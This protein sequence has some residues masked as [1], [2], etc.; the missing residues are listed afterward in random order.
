MRHI[1]SLGTLL[2]MSVVLLGSPAAA[3]GQAGGVA[4]E[5]LSPFA[6]RALTLLAVLTG[7]GIL[8]FLLLRFG[9]S[10]NSSDTQD[11]SDIADTPTPPVCPPGNV[12]PSAGVPT[13]FPMDG[14]GGA[15]NSGGSGG[16]GC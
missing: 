14:G 12:F 1:L 11:N 3:N 16:V 9:G 7:L 2:V 4:E 8:L 15:C 13:I 6:E 5:G 10:S